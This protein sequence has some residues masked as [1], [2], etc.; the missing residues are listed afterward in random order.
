MDKRIKQMVATTA[1][2]TTITS[3]PIIAQHHTAQVSAIKTNAI[4]I[5]RKTYNAISPSFSIFASFFML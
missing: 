1:N 2:M 3:P 4:N 5:E